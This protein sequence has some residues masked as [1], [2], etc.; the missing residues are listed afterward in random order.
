MSVVSK[1]L[2][3]YVF[4]STNKCI[5]LQTAPVSSN[6]TENQCRNIEQTAETY[7]KTWPMTNLV[8]PFT[9]TTTTNGSSKLV[10]TIWNASSSPTKAAHILFL[11]PS[12]Q[13][14]MAC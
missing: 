1:H 12:F 13:C 4:Q 9:I 5:Y 14:C 3:Q 6:L 8:S 2:L 11:L 7:N 10:P